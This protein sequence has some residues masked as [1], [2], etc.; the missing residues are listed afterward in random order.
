MKKIE[1]VALDFDGTLY[2][3]ESIR[4]P[5]LLRYWYRAKSLRAFLRARQAMREETFSDSEAMLDFQDRWVAERLN[6]STHKARARF[7]KLMIQGLNFHRI[8]LE[9]KSMNLNQQIKM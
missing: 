7:E 5:F 1:A 8:H 3:F 9:D 4:R 2:S 6:I